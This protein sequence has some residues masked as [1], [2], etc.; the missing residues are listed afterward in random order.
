MTNYHCYYH[1]LRG[2]SAPLW[3][4]RNTNSAD[5]NNKTNK[6]K[7]ILLLLSCFLA[8]WGSVQTASGTSKINSARYYAD[9]STISV[10]FTTDYTSNA[11]L[12]ISSQHKGS[13]T[14]P[15]CTSSYT[16]SNRYGNTSSGIVNVDPTLE[17]GLFQVLLYTNGNN[18]VGAYPVNVQ[19]TGNIKSVTPNIY[20]KTLT[21]NYSMQHGY[22]YSSSIRIYDEKHTRLFHNENIKKKSSDPNP[23]TNVYAY[24]N[25]T[26]PVN[27]LEYGNWYWCGLYSN[28]RLLKEIKFQWPFPPAVTGTIKEAVYTPGQKTIDVDYI[29]NNAA[30]A[31][32]YV[33]NGSGKVVKSGGAIANSSST[34]RF[35]FEN[36][37][38]ENGYYV[39]IIAKPY[40]E[41]NNKTTTISK[42]ISTVAVVPDPDNSP[43]YNSTE[44]VDLGYDRSTNKIY[45]DFQLKSSSL[46]N[47][48]NGAKVEIKLLP[49]SGNGGYTI[50]NMKSDGPWYIRQC[51]G[52]GYVGV[53]QESGTVLYIVFLCVNDEIAASK[54]IVISR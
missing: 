40:D 23:N 29:L 45:V 2:M 25:F 8:T 30:S 43:V 42:H 41:K 46:L 11:K 16:V 15:L 39:E 5:T 53:P 24:R 19:A 9:N 32:I 51:S 28:G 22:E 52:R 50:D 49:T 36:V 18:F 54:Q 35:T 47:R 38:F 44:I 48:P 33:Y 7:K 37:S 34:K 17:E 14:N 12:G 1:R 4:W 13:V 3:F 10:N 6:M 31:N 27:R 20:N 21:V 26:L